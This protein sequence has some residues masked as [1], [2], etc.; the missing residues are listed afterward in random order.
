MENRPRPGSRA[1]IIMTRYPEA[2]RVKTRLLPALGAVGA[3][4]LH[5]QM[6][7]HTVS[8][9]KVFSAAA[10]AGIFLFFQGGTKAL[11]TAWLGDEVEYLAQVAGDLGDKMRTAL[12]TV[13]KRGF[14]N[15]IIIGTDCPALDAEILAQAFSGLTRAGMVIGPAADGG[16][17]LLGLKQVYAQLFEGI[18]WGSDA[19]LKETLTAARKA[20]I[21]V[22]SLPELGDIDRP[23][24]LKN[25]KNLAAFSSWSDL[26]A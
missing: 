23:E 16:Y 19:V 21:R 25:L 8:S 15:V 20:G 5:R 10:G 4:R 26:S 6:V 11:M 13:F 22:Q 14:E 12:Q 3:A 18:S 9:V 7:E 2:G 1:I 17:Y 24:D